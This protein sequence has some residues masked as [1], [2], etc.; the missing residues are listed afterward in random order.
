MADEVVSYLNC[1][2]GGIYVDGTLGGAGHARFILEKT[3]PDGRVIGLDV[4]EDAVEQARVVLRPYGE[5]AV[6][7]REN[8]KNVKTVLT[9]EGIEGIDGMV[10]DAGVSSYQLGSPE[11]GFSFTHDARLDMRMD[12]RIKVSAYE[13]VNSLAE[14]ELAGIL[15]AYGEE[16]KARAIARAIVRERKIKPVATTGEL[17]SIVERCF[18]PRLRH[19][20][21]H[22]A[23]RVFQALRIAVN[24][25]L[26]NLKAGLEGGVLSLR[27]GGRMVVVSFHSLED[28]LVKTAFRR[29]TSGCVCP[30]DVP[31][32]VCGETP[33]ARLITK[34]AVF[35]SPGEIEA[36]PRARSA[37]LRA[38][39]KI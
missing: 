1:R 19:G 27:P 3:S 15:R 36:N 12:R 31:R 2:P 34:R 23:T 30:R 39:E 21:I 6:I 16:R 37:R 24:N 10:I 33:R 4:D 8:Y 11:R 28:R 26:E 18:S 38:V 29:M 22:P 35:P 32:C 5:R 14:G 9:R 25:E 17:A 13:L 7:L 20:R